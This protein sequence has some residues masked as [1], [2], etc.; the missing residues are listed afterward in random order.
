MRTII[1]R[2]WQLN[3]MAG[4]FKMIASVGMEFLITPCKKSFGKRILSYAHPDHRIDL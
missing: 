3:P 2:E 1:C 4:E